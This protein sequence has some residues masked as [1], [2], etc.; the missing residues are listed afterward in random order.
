MDEATKKIA[1]QIYNTGFRNGQIDMKNKILRRV[2][3]DWNLLKEH[4]SIGLMIKVLKIIDK[5]K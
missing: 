1:D 4:S 2:N 3:H 5:I